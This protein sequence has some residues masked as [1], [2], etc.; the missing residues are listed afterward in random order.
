MNPSSEMDMF[1]TTFPDTRSAPLV[2]HLRGEPREPGLTIRARHIAFV[3]QAPE[4]GTHAEI[5]VV[6]RH[7]ARVPPYLA[8][9]LDDAGQARR[10]DRAHGGLPRHPQPPLA[11]VRE[12]ARPAELPV[13]GDVEGRLQ[14][15]ILRVGAQRISER[16][17]PVDV[18]LA[19]VD[20]V[21]EV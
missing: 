5:H 21:G 7:P 17:V 2:P 3:P 13:A 16:A 10:G 9:L 4:A 6:A 18:V 11:V 20:A 1:R 19:I 8:P 12:I 15:N 14:I